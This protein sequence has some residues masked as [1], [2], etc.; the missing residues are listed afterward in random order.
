MKVTFIDPTDPNG[1]RE[2]LLDEEKYTVN[3][4]GEAVDA[5]GKVIKTKDE[6][7]ILYNEFKKPAGDG[8]SGTGTGGETDYTKILIPGAKLELDGVEYTL[9]NDLTIVKDGKIFKSKDEIINLLK[10]TNYKSE[11]DNATGTITQIQKATN[12]VITTPEGNPVEYDDSV[13][14]LT[15]YTQDVYATGVKLGQEQAQET[16]FSKYPILSDIIE[17]LELKGSIDGFV[18]NVD[19]NKITITEDE[20]QWLDIYTQA[21]L[22]R[23][24][25]K[26]EIDSYAKYLKDDGKLKQAATTALDFLKTTQTTEQSTRT[27]AIANK[28]KAEE[29]A[30]RAYMT[31][32]NKAL[33]SKQI[34]VG[35]KK[36][37]I[38]DVIRIKDAEGRVVTKSGDDFKRY[39]SEPKPFKIGD[40]VYTMTQ[41]AYDE[42]VEQNN[43]TAHNDLFDAYRR[44]TKYDDTQLIAAQV[45]NE[46]TKQIIKIVTKSGGGSGSSGA[47]STVKL[48]LPVK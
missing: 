6:V 29:D 9:T 32:I 38:P 37:A 26:A 41:H 48:K 2:L 27:Q 47:G 31:E 14:G 1:V 23:G 21:Q 15:R 30:E 4:N 5:T 24:I 40:K 8:G 33:T 25:P 22:K 12:L 43:R 45:S 13:E 44:F 20:N 19:Y 46:H 16:I 18:Q 42:L 35:T 17:H 3:A 28:K 39:I 36:F 11:D 7:D 10:E 34:V